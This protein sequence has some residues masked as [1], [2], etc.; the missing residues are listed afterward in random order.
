MAKKVKPFK[1]R[2]TSAALMIGYVNRGKRMLATTCG[3]DLLTGLWRA[4]AVELPRG[5]GSREHND[6]IFNDHSHHV[7]GDYIDFAAAL[8]ASEEYARAWF[9]GASPPAC[10]CGEIPDAGGVVLHSRE[11]ELVGVDFYGPKTGSSAAPTPE[12]KASPSRVQRTRAVAELRQTAR[13][14]RH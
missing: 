5:N 2:W 11:G 14:R 10:S 9:K 8:A 7:I 4:V 13:S 6:A 3:P 12:A 1:I